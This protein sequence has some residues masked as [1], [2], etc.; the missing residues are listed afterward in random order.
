MCYGYYTVLS[1]V[2]TFPMLHRGC[3]DLGK[4]GHGKM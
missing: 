4:E 2:L 3:H 1:K